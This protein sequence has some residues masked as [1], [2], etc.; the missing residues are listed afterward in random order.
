[1][2]GRNRS[3]LWR[4]E[5]AQ[6]LETTTSGRT[7]KIQIS[8][9]RYSNVGYSIFGIRH[10]NRKSKLI[11][12]PI[13][14]PILTSISISILI[15]TEYS[16]FWENSNF[17]VLEYSNIRYSN[18]GY[19]IFDIRHWNRKS[20]PKSKP[21]PKPKPIPI[22]TS[23]SISISINIEYS[24]F[25]ENS[26]FRVL[27][28]SSTRISNIRYS[29]VG[30]SIFDIRHWNRKSKPKP[31]PIPI[32]T[33]ISMSISIYIEYSNF[34]ENSNFRVLEYSNIEYSIFDYSTHHTLGV[35]L[36]PFQSCKTGSY[37][38]ARLNVWKNLRNFATIGDDSVWHKCF[39]Y[40]VWL[41]ITR[42]V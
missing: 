18:V 22:P 11:P 31:I 4:P 17:R 39:V 36:Q 41:R 9:I 5:A 34:G 6:S 8:N 1:M 33:S 15:N 32:P 14:I 30:Y 20:K 37:Q 13:P 38:Y 28:Y 12:K 25:G 29:N 7:L 3:L 27:E 21:M 2:H 40:K 24:N 42:N 19:S 16:K 35:Y 26:N 23:I 10:W